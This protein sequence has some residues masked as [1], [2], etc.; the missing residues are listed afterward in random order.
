ML[1]GEDIY[2]GGA[3]EVSLGQAVLCDQQVSNLC[4]LLKPHLILVFVLIKNPS[5]TQYYNILFGVI[6]FA[7]EVLTFDI[8][9]QILLTET[10]LAI[11]FSRKP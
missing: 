8:S 10:H 1:G 2:T 6:M 5:I 7:D 4:H 9:H 3:H 11:C